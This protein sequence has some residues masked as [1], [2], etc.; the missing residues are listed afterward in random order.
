MKVRVEC[1]TGHLEHVLEEFGVKSVSR[2][3]AKYLIPDPT[4]AVELQKYPRLEVIATPSTGTN[5]ID[6]KWC[7]KRGIKVLSLLDD[8]EGLAE[9]RA[10]SEFAFYMILSG[11]RLGGFRQWKKY[12]RNAEVMRGRELY[13]KHVGILGLGRIGT[14]VAKWVQAFGATWQSYDYGSSEESLL[15]IFD[16]CDIV[17]VSMSL[18]EKSKGLITD[19]HLSR[20][21]DGAILV[22]V[23]RAE[24]IEEAALI[25]WAASQKGLY[26]TDVLHREVLGNVASPLL[27]MT[28]VIITP[29]LAG[30]AAESTEKALRIAL[31][32]LRAEIE[33]DN[34][35]QQHKRDTVEKA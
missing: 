14:N 6:L 8:R 23:S 34:G 31:Q 7:E 16:K 32:L 25:K 22:N 26:V 17:L 1:P 5:H 20:M 30:E 33:R 15:E 11:L 21:K 28:N 24:I 27:E 35:K 12:N 19:K 3:W 4:R 13:G 9:I 18:N 10:S 29:H 2:E